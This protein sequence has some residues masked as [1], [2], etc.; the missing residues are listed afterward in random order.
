MATL[1]T[2]PLTATA[3][4]STVDQPTGGAIRRE[5]GRGRAGVRAQTTRRL[6]QLDVQVKIIT[7][8]NA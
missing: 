6:K 2:P 7:G 3:L 1:Q 4:V 5:L 8:D